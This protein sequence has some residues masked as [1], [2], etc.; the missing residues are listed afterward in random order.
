M[1]FLLIAA[2]AGVYYRLIYRPAHSTSNEF[3]YALNRSVEVMDTPAE[4]RGVIAT[5]NQ[6]ERAEVLERTRNW[7]RVRLAN[8]QVGWVEAK[9]MLDAQDYEAGRRLLAELEKLPA[10]ALGHTANTANFRLEPS[11]DAQQIA[12]IEAQRK[13]AI[14]GRRSVERAPEPTAASPKLSE[15]APV[16][17][18]PRREVWYL[19]R[20]DSR[21]G[22]VLGRLVALDIPESI[23]MYAQGTNM[24][25]WLVLNTVEDNGQQVPQY[26]T[27]DRIGAQEVDFNHIRVLTWWKKRHEYVTAYVESNLNGYFPIRISHINGVPY[28]RLR[29]M[30]EDGAKIQKVYRLFDT[31]TRPLG[32]VEG[33][34]SDAM[35][36]RPI[37][38]RKKVRAGWPPRKRHFP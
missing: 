22:W 10:H 31:I 34:E 33:W 20:T 12:Q 36:S 37:T 4:V 11:R 1:I 3:V 29:L 17:G 26:L 7:V 2:G 38:R 15:K 24:V 35:P 30:D 23:S 27:A 28:F 8:S 6:G 5:L 16:A 14:F 21:A 19:V 25:A 32:I 18:P 9:N 13:V